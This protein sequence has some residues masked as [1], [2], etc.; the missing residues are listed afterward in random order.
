MAESELG[1]RFV[2]YLAAAK[3]DPAAGPA[4]GSV[5]MLL[6]DRVATFAE[7]ADAAHYFYAVPHPAAEKI[8]EFVNDGN[9]AAL[10]QL[11]ADLESIEWQ[12]EPILTPSRPMPRIMA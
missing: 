12:R 1:P 7:M 9:R 2:P 8:A 4:P 10:G 5:A 3:L 6:R 11:A